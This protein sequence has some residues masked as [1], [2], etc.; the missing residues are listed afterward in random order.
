[1]DNIEL[2]ISSGLV[3]LI[4]RNR[5]H[6]EATLRILL[7]KISQK[8]PEDEMGDVQGISRRLLRALVINCLYKVP[9][10]EYSA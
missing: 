6:M 5:G 8:W 9:K 3:E 10:A 4:E 2:G 7:M 1:M